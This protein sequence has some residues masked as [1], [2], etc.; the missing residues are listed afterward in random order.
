MKSER[1]LFLAADYAYPVQLSLQMPER[2]SHKA[3][4]FISKHMAELKIIKEIDI[5]SY[6]GPVFV[7]AD[8][9]RPQNWHKIRFK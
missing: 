7:I 5:D 3:L 4:A 9:R 2:D 8:A 1:F 6:D